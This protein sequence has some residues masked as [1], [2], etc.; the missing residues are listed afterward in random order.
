MAWPSPVA[1]SSC[2]RLARCNQRQPWRSCHST[3]LFGV[4]IAHSRH[5]LRGGLGAASEPAAG[6]LLSSASS[7]TVGVTR[8][9]P[10]CRRK[11]YA[12]NVHTASSRVSPARSA[13]HGTARLVH[14]DCPHCACSV[15]AFDRTL[16]IMTSEW[17][18][19]QFS[20]LVCD[21]GRTLGNRGLIGNTRS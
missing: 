15:A 4:I 6:P 3:L 19:P 9:S 8:W 2:W 10:A 12:E 20:R 14:L 21:D 13:Q 1:V 18:T 16:A 17:G 11:T 7:A 5:W